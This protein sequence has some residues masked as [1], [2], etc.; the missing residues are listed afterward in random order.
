MGAPCDVCNLAGNRQCTTLE[1]VL[2]PII[3]ALLK[4]IVWLLTVAFVV[5]GI[6]MLVQGEKLYGIIGLVL[7]GLLGIF[8]PKV[9]YRM[10]DDFL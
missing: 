7:A 5:G 9:D 8:L 10:I 1:D 6:A 4:V 3:K 2:L